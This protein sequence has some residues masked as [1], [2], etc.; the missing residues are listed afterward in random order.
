MIDDKINISETDKKI[1]EEY[2]KVSEQILE[3]FEKNKEKT[4]RGDKI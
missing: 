2:N 3:I 4:G 1:K